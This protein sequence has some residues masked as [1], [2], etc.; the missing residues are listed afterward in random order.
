MKQFLRSFFSIY[1]IKSFDAF[2]SFHVVHIN[3]K[4]RYDE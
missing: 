1:A 4:I 2:Q 3:V